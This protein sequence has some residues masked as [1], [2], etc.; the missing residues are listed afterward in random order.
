MEMTKEQVIELLRKVEFNENGNV[1]NVQVKNLIPNY[2]YLP[3]YREWEDFT[4]SFDFL[5]SEIIEG[6]QFRIKPQKQYRPYTEVSVDWVGK[7]LIDK[8][9]INVNG[10]LIIKVKDTTVWISDCIYGLKDML[11]IFTWLDGTPFGEEV[12]V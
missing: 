1:E 10:Y 3:E 5:L 9:N 6:K 11:E 8:T 7:T 12:E 4:Q 2:Y